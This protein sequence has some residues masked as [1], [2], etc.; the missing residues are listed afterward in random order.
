MR[1][2]R[3]TKKAP[4]G[5]YSIGV[6]SGKEIRRLNLAKYGVKVVGIIDKVGGLMKTEGFTLDEIKQ[7]FHDKDGN[8]LVADNLIP[9]DKINE[10]I[11]SMGAEIFIPAA[12]SR[13]V[14]QDQ[15]ESMINNNL[16]VVSCGANVPFRDEEIFYGPIA[17]FVDK[18]V[19]LLPDFIANCGMA[20][21]FAFLMDPDKDEVLTDADIFNDCSTTIGNAL[22]EVHNQNN[23]RVNL[24]ETAFTISLNKL[25]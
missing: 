9:F 25:V 12:A 17:E 10:E 2:L 6:N 18:K 21:T 1:S 22:Q 24:A 19:S 5:N 15:A 13:L 7:L 4:A 20:R 23:S 14:T 3:P 16:E 11:W 8:K